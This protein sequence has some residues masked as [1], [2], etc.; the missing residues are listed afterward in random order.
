MGMGLL[1][2]SQRR[3]RFGFCWFMTKN[4][5]F[6]QIGDGKSGEVF[7]HLEVISRA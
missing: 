4:L 6:F 2:S 5:P 1:A 7:W 3:S